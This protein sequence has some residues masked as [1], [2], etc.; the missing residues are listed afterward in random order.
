MM[1]KRAFHP[2]KAREKQPES[3]KQAE[4]AL[5]WLQTILAIGRTGRIA[6]ALGG[7]REVPR[8]LPKFPVRV[9]LTP[10]SAGYG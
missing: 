9:E 4:T 1:G 2:L 6:R 3:S 8:R 7:R 5:A 10:I